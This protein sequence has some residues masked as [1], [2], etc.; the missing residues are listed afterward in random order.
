MVSEKKG[1]KY[2][3]VLQSTKKTWKSSSSDLVSE[4]RCKFA[5]AATVP[6]TALSGRSR[7][8]NDNEKGS[9]NLQLSILH[10]R[11]SWQINLKDLKS[12]LVNVTPEEATE[13]HQGAES[14][15]VVLFFTTIGRKGEEW[16]LLLWSSEGCSGLVLVYVRDKT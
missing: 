3:Y 8:E 5:V 9:C 4:N 16:I 11:F 6:R 10:R 1:A 12:F 15:S 14:Y 13:S 7:L 2:R